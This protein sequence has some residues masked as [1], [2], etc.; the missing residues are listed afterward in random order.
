MRV[1]C[2]ILFALTLMISSCR[3]KSIFTKNEDCRELRS[4]VKKNWEKHPVKDSYVTNINFLDKLQRDYKNCI[5]DCTKSD[6]MEIFGKPF[7]Q[8]FSV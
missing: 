4:L 2:I 6:I 5:L 8:R 3:M 1:L 7:T